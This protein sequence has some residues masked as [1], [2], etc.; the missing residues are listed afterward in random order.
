MKWSA[1]IAYAVG[2]ITT[3]GSLSNDGRHIIFRSSDPQL[4]ETF[5]KCL[6]LSNKISLT[7][8][9]L[10]ATRPAYKLQFGNVKFYRWLNKIGL[11]SNKTKTISSLKINKKY[12]PDFLRGHLDGDGSIATYEDRSLTKINPKY[13]Y[14]RLQVR[15]QSASKKHI[16]W[17]QKEV[18]KLMNVKG[19]IT[20]QKPREYQTI[21]AWRLV[22]AKKK[23]IVLLRR[24]YYKEELP[25]L[26]RKREIAYKFVR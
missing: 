23:S 2:L 15:F 6:S 26:I 17:L 12:F 11:Y 8:H 7:K 5:K 20:Y 14:I 21:G 4:L 1:D 10:W 19:F 3:D 18:E 13:I 22:F 9:D 16:Y 24:I 25:C